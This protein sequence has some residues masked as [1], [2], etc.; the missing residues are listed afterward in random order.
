MPKLKENH[1]HIPKVKWKMWSLC[2]A[3]DCWPPL[4]KHSINPETTCHAAPLVPSCFIHQRRVMF[5][6]SWEMHLHLWTSLI[7]IAFFF[8]FFFFLWE[9][10]CA[11]EDSRLHNE[12][13][14]F[15]LT[16]F[17]HRCCALLHGL[18][19]RSAPILKAN[20][21]TCFPPFLKNKTKTLIPKS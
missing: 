17:I 18:S 21:G 19:V 12:S 1:S 14:L 11:E 8:F 16:S 10:D 3:P 6:V 2:R 7:L 13:R 20:S 9:M 4:Y 5:H 15:L